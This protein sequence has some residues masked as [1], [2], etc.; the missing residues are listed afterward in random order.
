[1][2]SRGYSGSVGDLGD[3]PD[4]PK[5]LRAQ[6]HG[7]LGDAVIVVGQADRKRFEQRVKRRELRALDVPVRDLD[8]AVQVEAVRQARVERV[9]DI[10]AGGFRQVTWA[11]VHG[12]LR[13]VGR[14]GSF[15]R[16]PRSFQHIVS[17]AVI[18][19]GYQRPRRNR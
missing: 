1:V 15:R 6:R 17:K 7:A 13:F 10:G 12:V 2:A 18:G 11:G 16:G 4:R 5:R 3:V 19:A 8:L 9:G 14:G